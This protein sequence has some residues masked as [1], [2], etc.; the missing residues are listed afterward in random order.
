QTELYTV[1]VLTPIVFVFAEVVPK[2]LFQRNADTLMA[3]FSR[4][5]GIATGVFRGVG[6]VWIITRISDV[7]TRFMPATANRAS[8][9]Q[10]KRRMAGMLREALADA[11]GGDEQSELVDRIVHLSE[12]RVHTVMVP[13][14]R[15]VTIAAD[16]D[17][18]A[19][20]AVARRVPHAR[21]PVY[22]PAPSS[23]VRTGARTPGRAH[24]AR[25]R[26]IG[27]IKVDDLLAR[28]DWETV[29]DGLRPITTLTPH[30]TV[31]AAI[32]DLQRSGYGMAV[33]TDRGGQMLGIV[34]F[35]DLIEE[36]VGEL[37]AW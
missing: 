6:A 4:L 8:V 10:P 19:L 29:A 1:I 36:L 31:A 14:N 32:T 18:T 7:V 20:V 22:D 30:Q 27:L 33:V 24:I 5:L 28:D 9:A 3:R 23:T 17:R 35:K 16:A 37:T 15:V 25:R 13:R 11:R 34:T 12:T 21:L 26:M 2:N